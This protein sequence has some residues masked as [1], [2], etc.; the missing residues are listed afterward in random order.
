MEIN[1]G[2]LYRENQL[3]VIFMVHLKWKKNTGEKIRKQKR[4]E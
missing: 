1:Y 4:L 3:P 2:N